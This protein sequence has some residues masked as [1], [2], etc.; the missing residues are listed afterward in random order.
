[1]RSTAQIDKLALAVQR[2]VLTLGQVLDDF[3][4]IFFIFL[5]EVLDRFTPVPDLALHRQGILDDAAHFRPNA[6]E[7]IHREAGRIGEIVEKAVLDH[8]ADGALG[9]RIKALHRLRHQV[10]GRM[11]NDFKPFRIPAGDDAKGGISFDQVAGIAQH[12]IHFAGQGRL[13]QARADSGRH[14]HDR[15]RLV[16][17]FLA[18]IG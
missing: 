10:R 17:L 14:V 1:V 6:I 16:E 13:G 2:D 7:V 8:R 4:L 11:A 5:A 12:A 9:L 18:P 15:D 3:G